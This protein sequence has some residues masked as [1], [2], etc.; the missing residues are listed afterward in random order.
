MV[1]SSGPSSLPMSSAQDTQNLYG[2]SKIVPKK[3]SNKTLTSVGR[4]SFQP[5]PDEWLAGTLADVSLN[6]TGGSVRRRPY[7]EGGTEKNND[8]MAGYEPLLA[9]DSR[10]M[11]HGDITDVRPEAIGTE[12]AVSRDPLEE[13]D[14]FLRGFS[15]ESALHDATSQVKGPPTRRHSSA[16]NSGAVRDQ[17]PSG[18]NQAF[19]EPLLPYSVARPQRNNAPGV[20]Q[21]R[22]NP[23]Q[24]RPLNMER[25]RDEP[26]GSSPGYGRAANLTCNPNLNIGETLNK[27][28]H[29]GTP[30]HL[31]V[32]NNDPLAGHKIIP[33]RNLYTEERSQPTGMENMEQSDYHAGAAAPTRTCPVC[34]DDYPN[35]TQLEFEGHVFRC[36]E[37]PTE[38][39]EL[40]M[41]TNTR[42]SGNKEK[43]CPVCNNIF[44][45]SYKQE[46]FELH[47]DSHF[48][49][50]TSSIINQFELIDPHG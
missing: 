48:K 29:S 20:S 33:E 30:N 45:P 8:V 41:T 35:M 40:T 17:S 14:V 5:L 1:S 34:N 12:G 31:P 21:A 3:G 46:D 23:A 32:L 25:N 11:A 36:V 6:N 38:N 42:D 37:S 2:D 27:T 15:V 24:A 50:E 19:T 26:V 43:V 47:V 44:P 22:N 4:L 49:H 39:E 16:L 10:G 9:V 18:V 13:H 7:S 28:P